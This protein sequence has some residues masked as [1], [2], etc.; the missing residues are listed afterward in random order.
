MTTQTNKFFESVAKQHFQK[1]YW[2]GFERKALNMCWLF[3]PA[4]FLS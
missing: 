4:K 3:I 1:I 2:F